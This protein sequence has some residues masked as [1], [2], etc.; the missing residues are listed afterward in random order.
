MIKAHKFLCLIHPEKSQISYRKVNFP[1]GQQDIV[2]TFFGTISEED[3]ANTRVKLISR[4]NN[5]MDIEM[6]ICA[7]NALRNIG[8]IRID[9]HVPYILGARS[10]RKFVE[11]GVSY[12]RQVIGPL[13]NMQKYDTVTCVDIHN[14]AVSEACIDNIV[15]QDNSKLVEFAF[16]DIGY[17]ESIIVCPDDGASKKI[18]PLCK[19]IG[20]TGDVLV[21]SKHRNTTTG[22]V[23]SVVI[24]EVE[25]VANKNVVIID[26]ICDGGR[27]FIEL[28]K[29]MAGTPRKSISLVVTHGIFSAGLKELSQHFKIIYTT[30]SYM[31]IDSMNDF[32]RHNERYLNSIKQLKI[33]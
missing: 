30:N 10:D 22:K 29:A 14:M 13:I 11:G 26:D 12:L 19:K 4:L 8:V 20:Y 2:L 5:F 18:Y 27:T 15:V 1:D 31:D 24:P 21:C 16:N 6:I 28:S 9:L 7:T 23:E 32:G 33:V 25:R 3:P 17:D